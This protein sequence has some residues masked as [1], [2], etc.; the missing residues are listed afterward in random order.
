MSKRNRDYKAEYARRKARGLA[1]GLSVAQSR[2]HPRIGESNV[3][4][5]R[6]KKIGAVQFNRA[7]KEL[8]RGST[9][10]E[11]SRFSGIPYDRLRGDSNQYGWVVRDGRRWRISDT[12][13]RQVAIFSDRSLKEI[14]VTDPQTLSLIGHYNNDIGKFRETNNVA[15]LEKYKGVAVTDKAGRSYPLETDPNNIYEILFAENPRPEEIYNFVPPAG[16]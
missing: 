15:F 4:P 6:R 5:K 13:E 11:A 12:L 2:G 14:R 10:R 1:K 8:S 16:F 3:S 9:M 7:L